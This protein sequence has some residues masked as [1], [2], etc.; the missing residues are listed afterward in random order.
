MKICQIVSKVQIKNNKSN[1]S[2]RKKNP[3]SFKSRSRISRMIR[4]TME[5]KQTT[6]TTRICLIW[7][8]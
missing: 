2:R 8:F 5:P 7:R 1:K 3:T 4:A 6:T